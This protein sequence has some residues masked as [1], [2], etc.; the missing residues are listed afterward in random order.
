VIEQR[1][2]LANRLAACRI[3]P[4]GT[5]PEFLDHD[6]DLGRDSAQGCLFGV[7]RQRIL[8]LNSK[9]VVLYSEDDGLC[10]PLAKL[11]D[12]LGY[13]H[14]Y[15]EKETHDSDPGPVFGSFPTNI[16]WETAYRD[17]F[18]AIGLKTPHPLEYSQGCPWNNDC[19][20]SAEYR[21]RLSAHG[22]MRLITL[23]DDVSRN[24][25]PYVGGTNLSILSRDSQYS[26]PESQ[27]PDV[28]QYNTDLSVLFSTENH[29]ADPDS[30]DN[31]PEDDDKTISLPYWFEKLDSRK[32]LDDYRRYLDGSAIQ[33]VFEYKGGA[34]F[35]ARDG[36]LLLVY[37]VMEDGRMDDV[38][39]IE[40]SD[41]DH[42]PFISH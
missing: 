25:S 17:R 35:T 37:R 27:I 19:P 24:G 26:Q 3:S 21:V 1:K 38:C 42:D 22:P 32:S 11:Y 39:Y 18:A 9:T 41:I 40:K 6:S 31:N 8:D 34:V 30:K 23:D 4:T 13:I 10:K 15:M 5:V 33:R 28:D 2:W 20:E 29:P 16:I 7:Y 14:T 36:T 12:E